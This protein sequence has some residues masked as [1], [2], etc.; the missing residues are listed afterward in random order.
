M[1][2]AFDPNPSTK[3]PQGYWYAAT[4]DGNNDADGATPLNAVCALV[5]EIEKE[6]GYQP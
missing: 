2:L 3:Y 5:A 1:R 4:A 6:R